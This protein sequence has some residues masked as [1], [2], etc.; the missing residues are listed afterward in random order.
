MRISILL[1]SFHP[2]FAFKPLKKLNPE[3]PS[4]SLIYMVQ[5][6]DPRSKIQYK[7]LTNQSSSATPR[8][9]F[10]S[11]IIND[12]LF[13]QQ[14]T[15]CGI[16]QLHQRPISPACDAWWENKLLMRWELRWMYQRAGK[17]VTTC[18]TTIISLHVSRIGIPSYWYSYSVCDDQWV[19][20]FMFGFDF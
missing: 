4:W 20:I 1:S 10:C 14:L 13:H 9:K 17:H 3:T 7:L 18:H 12:S 11:S 6:S 5:I 19:Y 2:V 16:I 8:I 15:S